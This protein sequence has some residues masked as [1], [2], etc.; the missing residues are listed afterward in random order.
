MILI[1]T[2]SSG[3]GSAPPIAATLAQSSPTRTRRALEEIP[4][5]AMLGILKAKGISGFPSHLSLVLD[6]Y[7][8]DILARIFAHKVKLVILLYAYS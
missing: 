8:V 5:P 4:L 1:G 6:T 3:Q 2:E 7:P